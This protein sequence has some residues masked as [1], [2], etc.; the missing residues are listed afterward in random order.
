VPS[1]SLVAA[2]LAQAGWLPL[3]RDADWVVAAKP[4]VG[5]ESADAAEP[6]ET[7]LAMRVPRLPRV[8]R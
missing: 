3:Y 8:Q 7:H 4:A 1:G 2:R 5:A 6:A